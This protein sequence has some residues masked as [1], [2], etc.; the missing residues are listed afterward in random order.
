V[1]RIESRLLRLLKA[2]FIPITMK[3]F[4]RSLDSANL[5]FK[6]SD[7]GAPLR[8]DSCAAFAAANSISKCDIVLSMSLAKKI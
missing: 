7:K 1:L 3:Y 5:K 8:R 2:V 6:S 4:D